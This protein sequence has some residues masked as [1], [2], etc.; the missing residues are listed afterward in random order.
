MIRVTRFN[1]KEYI[2]NADL[3]EFVEETPD[4]VITLVTGRKV[5]VKETSEEVIDLVIEY[6]RRVG[7]HPATIQI[8]DKNQVNANDSEK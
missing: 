4:T 3:I 6:R 1:G 5:L 7:C 2:V 8:K